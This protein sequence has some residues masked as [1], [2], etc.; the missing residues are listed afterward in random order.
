MKKGMLLNKHIF[1][2][3]NIWYNIFGVKLHFNK[4]QYQLFRYILNNAN[5][6]FNMYVKIEEP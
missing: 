5:I 2:L 1:F 4:Y 3:S 6:R